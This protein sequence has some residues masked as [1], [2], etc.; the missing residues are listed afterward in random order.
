[1]RL[2]TFTLAK[3]KKACLQRCMLARTSVDV[4]RAHPTLSPFLPL[5]QTP[6]A[7]KGCQQHCNAALHS[8]IWLHAQ[9]MHP[10]RFP[11]LV[12]TQIF[13]RRQGLPANAPS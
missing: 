11:T 5:Q 8:V 2:W 1:M 3:D 6:L 12:S 10:R 9:P 13:S 7:V 4:L